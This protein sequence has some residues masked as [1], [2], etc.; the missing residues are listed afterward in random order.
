GNYTIKRIVDIDPNNLWTTYGESSAGV[1][2]VT[3]DSATYSASVKTTAEVKPKGTGLL[4][5]AV[6]DV[7]QF[8]SSGWKSIV[9]ILAVA[10]IL[11]IF[12]ISRKQRLKRRF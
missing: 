9:F 2:Q 3:E 6:I 11:A 1:V 12:I 8:F 7:K 5:G 4:T 10:L